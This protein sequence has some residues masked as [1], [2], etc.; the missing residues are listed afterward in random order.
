MKQN[1]NDKLASKI[2]DA[3]SSAMV[4]NALNSFPSDLPESEKIEATGASS[5]GGYTAPLFG[6]MKEQDEQTSDLTF[7]KSKFDSND[8]SFTAAYKIIDDSSE[9]VIEV[10]NIQEI[11]NENRMFFDKKKS[12]KIKIH[13]FR[14]PK[15]QVTILDDDTG[16]KGFKFIKIPYWLVK[17]NPEQFKII[18]IN[19]RKRL[20][21]K[22]NYKE[23]DLAD[24]VDE[25]VVDYI[26]VT[27]GDIESI[28]KIKI[29][30][31]G[32]ITKTETKEA[33]G[34]S[35]AGAYVGPQVWAKTSTKKNWR[36]AR[37]TQLPGGK[38]VEVKKKC[39][40]FPYCNQGDIKALNIFENERIQEVIKNIS[41]KH[42]IDENVIKNILSY[43]MQIFR[44]NKK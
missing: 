40:K 24:K 23:N 43:E 15:S 12:Y 16:F 13:K 28:R 6:D 4:S 37:K 3:Q 21:N 41:K 14:L 30:Q 36:G 39:Q 20:D 7:Y 38:F 1:L 35:S 32:E 27:D 31:G 25:D 8:N 22:Y 5:A 9:K 34:A 26:R 33:T 2:T 44:N 11:K 19:D 18:R 29:Q 42:K 17:K 10:L